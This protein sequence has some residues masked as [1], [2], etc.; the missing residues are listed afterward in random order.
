MLKIFC[1]LSLRIECDAIGFRCTVGKL[2]MLQMVFF[3]WIVNWIISCKW[4]VGVLIHCLAVTRRICLDRWTNGSTRPTPFS[5]SILK[6]SLNLFL[7]WK[8]TLIKLF[9]KNYTK[10]HTCRSLNFS[11]IANFFRSSGER[12]LWLLNSCSKCCVCC[13]VK[14]TWPPFRLNVQPGRI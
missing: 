14:R 6:P 12:Y 2:I 7:N 9:Q 13:G 11:W 5:S 1:L 10:R 3:G 8:W 4:T